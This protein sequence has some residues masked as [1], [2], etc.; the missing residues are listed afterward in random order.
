MDEVK[1]DWTH[2]NV[3]IQ[4]IRKLSNLY[5][6]KINSKD[7]DQTLFV[8][9]NIFDERLRTYFLIDSLDP[10]TIISRDQ[11]LGLRWNFHITQGYLVKFEDG[12]PIKKIPEEEKEDKYYVSFL[13]IAGSLGDFE[14]VKN[15]KK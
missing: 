11:I 1:E 10:T 9:R 3:E 12:K 6:I 5:A 2:K 14:S 15:K 4:D 8:K 13:E 7:I